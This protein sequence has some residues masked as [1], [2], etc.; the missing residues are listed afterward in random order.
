MM[1]RRPLFTTLLLTI[2][3]IASASVSAKEGSPPAAFVP[4]QFSN[5]DSLGVGKLLVAKRGVPDLTFAETVILLVRYD[6][7][8][9]VQGLVLNR[10]MDIPIS[11]VLDLQSA[12]NR[13]D[14][15]YAGGPVGFRQVFALIKSP[16][17]M[18]KAENI[19]GQVYL[20]SDKEL[21]DQTLSAN[22]KPNS[23]R[24][25]VGYTGWTEA[26]LR[27]EVQV[28]AWYVFPGDD[29]VVFAPNPDAVWKQMIQKT[30]AQLAMV[31][32]QK[33]ENSSQ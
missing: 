7:E 15:T 17:K 20:I 6:P 28:G 31:E 18:E 22:P 16:V 33:T 19:F 10:R 3:L 14:L 26:Q 5:P 25:Y 12:K 8:R 24:L 2:A 13:K 29:A 9:G 27:H 21:F 23:L 30:K 4:A 1:P 11:K 32:G